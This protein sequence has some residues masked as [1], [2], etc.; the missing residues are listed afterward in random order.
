MPRIDSSTSLSPGDED[1]P[2][3]AADDIQPAFQPD[4]QVPGARVASDGPQ[5]GG[6]CRTPEIYTASESARQH[7]ER[8]KRTQFARADTRAGF[9]QYPLVSQAQ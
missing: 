4:R 7:Y 1:S 9:R 8:N 2:V 3:T 5:D 6:C